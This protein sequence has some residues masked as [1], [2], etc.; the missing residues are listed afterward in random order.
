MPATPS[1]WPPRSSDS[2]ALLTAY[3]QVMGWAVTLGHDPAGSGEGRV[4][5]VVSAGFDALVVPLEA[6]RTALW[7]VERSKVT[8]PALRNPV[9]GSVAFLV[10]AGSAAALELPAGVGVVPGR[11]GLVVAPTPGV[12]WDTT[13]WRPDRREP[14]PFPPARAVLPAVTDTLRTHTAPSP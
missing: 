6:G 5:T 2:G 8:A 4:V 1:S 12:R 10:A 11:E 3:T 9:L 13:P 7:A 14:L